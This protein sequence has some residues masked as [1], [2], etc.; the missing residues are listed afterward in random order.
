M[1]RPIDE[2]IAK[3]TL[4]NSDLKDKAIESSQIFATLSKDIANS[5]DLGAMAD[6]IEQIAN[7]FSTTG[8][9]FQ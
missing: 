6:N 1:S 7:K 2:K 8:I 9:M 4:D 5:A 3:L